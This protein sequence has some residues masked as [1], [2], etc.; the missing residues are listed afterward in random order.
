MMP[1]IGSEAIASGALTRGQLRWNYTAVHPDV[2]LPNGAGK[3]LYTNAFAAWLW[4][5]RRGVIAGRAAAGLYG[6]QWIDD[7][8]PIELIGN[9]GRGRPG[10]VVRQERI[11]EDEI[12]LIGEMRVTTPARTG[13][14]IARRIPRYAAVA[15]LDA[16]AAVMG[17]TP[18]A[19]EDLAQRYSGARGICAARDAIEVMDG[20]ALCPDET[21][22]RLWLIDAGFPRPRTDIEI[23]DGFGS[24]RVAMGWDGPK[25]CVDFEVHSERNDRYR[26][27]QEITHQDVLRRAGWLAVRVVAQHPRRSTVERVREAFRQRRRR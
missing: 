7:N 15:D 13:L 5:R 6:V 21:R 16:L 14:D 26:V 2:Y 27:V 20:G 8:E 11:T 1:I 25:I 9:H 4:S 3:R 12:R 18:A 22:V 24:T 10:I 19:M 17:V 23:D